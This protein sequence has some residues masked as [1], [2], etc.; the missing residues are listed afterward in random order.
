MGFA[1]LVVNLQFRY[2][3]FSN[4]VK[5][6]I[7]TLITELHL[8]IVIWNTYQVVCA[9]SSDIGIQQYT[10]VWI[11]WR[12]FHDCGGYFMTVKAQ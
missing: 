11:M 5:L 6:N 8:L 4:T 2:Q 10:E 9:R 1:G 7:N 3:P 12:A